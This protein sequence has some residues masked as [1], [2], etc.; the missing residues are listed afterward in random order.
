MDNSATNREGFSQALPQLIALT[1]E[2]TKLV[3]G[4][5]PPPVVPERPPSPDPTQPPPDGLPGCGTKGN[6]GNPLFPFH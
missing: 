1:S 4:G 3:A 2:E 6:G 5:A